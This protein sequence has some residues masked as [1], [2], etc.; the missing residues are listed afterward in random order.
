[1]EEFSTISVEEISKED[2]LLIIKALEYTGEQ[3]NISSFIELKNTIV[4]QLSIL[5]NATEEE[6]I[7]FLRK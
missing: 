7:E 2:M 6:F 1:M 5:A 4:K 3:T